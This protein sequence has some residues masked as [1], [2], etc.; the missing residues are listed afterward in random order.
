MIIVAQRRNEVEQRLEDI[1]FKTVSERL[2]GLIL[3]LGSKFGEDVKG[4][5]KINLKLIHYDI[6]NLIGSTRETTTAVLNEFKKEGLITIQEKMIIIL[7]KK[8]LEKK[9]NPI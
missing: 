6:A 1:V 5:K 2:A 4:G 9:N 3:T 7:D 8:G